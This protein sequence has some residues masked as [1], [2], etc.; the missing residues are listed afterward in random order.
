MLLTAAPPAASP[1]SGRAR[2]GRG[3]I[4]VR[5]VLAVVLVLSGALTVTVLAAGTANAAGSRLTT[6]DSRMLALV[7]KARIDAGVTEL[8]PASGLTNLSVMWSSKMA[9]GAT[10]NQLQ[11]NPNAFEQT[12]SYGASNRT[13]WGENVAKWSPTSTSADEIFNAYMASPGHKANILGSAYRYVGIGSVTGSNGASW[14]TMTFT[15]KVEAGQSLATVA[16]ADAVSI[17]SGKVRATGWAFDPGSSGASV[18]VLLYVNNVLYNGTADQSRPDVNNAYGISGS[19][20][21]TVTAPAIIG[22]NVV[23]LY[24]A[25][26]TGA[27]T[28]GVYCATLTLDPPPS[29]KAGV[30]IVMQSG[31]K[32]GVG[33][34]AFDPSKTGESIPVQVN[35]NGQFGTWL[36][37]DQS[38]PDINATNGITGNH[39]FI[40]YL[41]TKPGWNEVCLWGI[42]TTGGNHNFLGCWNVYNDTLPAAGNLDYVTRN[43]GSVRLTGWAYDPKAP[44]ATNPVHV[45]VDGVGTAFSTG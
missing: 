4:I 40:G 6:F 18:P 14:D 32:V 2:P 31:A 7:N 10:G 30:E 13:A 27:G 20:G 36:S 41:D 44:S 29:P 24:A 5:A 16:T 23:C 37:A 35:I 45:Y 15:D 38:R 42:S 43:G 11:H 8:K 22:K 21:F 28:T 9:D 39:G 12:L 3:M 19:H 34:W 17:V 1:I 25:S 26:V 33:G